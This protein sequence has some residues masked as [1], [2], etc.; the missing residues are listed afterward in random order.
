MSLDEFVEHENR[1]RAIADSI[2]AARLDSIETARQD[3]IAATS[4]NQAAADSV[5]RPVLPPVE[6]QKQPDRR[7]KQPAAPTATGD[8]AGVAYDIRERVARGFKGA[9]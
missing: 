9:F 3:S 8:T 2:A 7:P 5:S 6:Q 1:R 4:G